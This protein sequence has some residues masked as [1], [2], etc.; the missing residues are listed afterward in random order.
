LAVGDLVSVKNNLLMRTITRLVFCLVIAVPVLAQDENNF[1]SSWKYFSENRIPLNAI[2]PST[3][4]R[5]HYNC[6]SMLFARGDF[7][8]TIKIWT[9]GVEWGYTLNEFREFQSKPGY[10]RQF[11][12]KSIS[13]D[14]RIF[15]V[16]LQETQ[17]VYRN[18]SLYQISDTISKPAEY[19]AWGIDRMMGKIDEETYRRR[20]DSIDLL[21]RDRHAYVAKLIYVKVWFRN[22]KNRLR[23]SRDVNFEGDEIELEKEWEENGKK[24]FVLRIN[25][26]HEGQ[27]TSY[28]Y[29]LNEDMKFVWWEGC[30]GR[31]AAVKS[32][33]E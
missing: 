30:T 26:Y 21:Y 17:F 13:S 18:D 10:G 15:M 20:K 28:A 33:K 1:E 11:F 6:D 8:D 22:G 3:G 9:P 14:G 23:L 2:E 4:F 5:I 7:G 12:P 31:K 32:Q 29:A 25:N 27:Q 19:F 24:C 16:Y